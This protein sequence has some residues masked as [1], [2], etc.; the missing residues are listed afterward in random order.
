LSRRGKR[1]FVSAG[2]QKVKRRGDSGLEPLRSIC[3]HLKSSGYV[4]L[5]Q[6]PFP[7]YDVFKFRRFRFNLIRF[8]RLPLDIKERDLRSA[9]MQCSVNVFA[10]YVAR[11]RRA[12]AESGGPVE[13]TFRPAAHTIDRADEREPERVAAG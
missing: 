13:V 6:P 12:V 9:I 7:A 3:A 11:A 4:V 10:D 1:V 2:L 5:P 8:L